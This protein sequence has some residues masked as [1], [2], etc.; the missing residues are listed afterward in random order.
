MSVN[1]RL[2]FFHQLGPSMYAILWLLTGVSDAGSPLEKRGWG[3][4]EGLDSGKFT[5]GIGVHARASP[6]LLVPIAWREACGCIPGSLRLVMPCS[7]W[8]EWN[9]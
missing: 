7:C 9:L 6:Y 3:E 8:V 5:M 1:F 4:E 2:A